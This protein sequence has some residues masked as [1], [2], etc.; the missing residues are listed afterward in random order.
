MCSC[1]CV[2]M[3]VCVCPGGGQKTTSSHPWACHPP[4]LKQ[5][6]S[7]GCNS[8]MGY[9]N[10]HNFKDTQCHNKLG[11]KSHAQRWPRRDGNRARRITKGYPFA[12][13][14]TSRLLDTSFLPCW[15][16]NP[17]SCTRRHITFTYIS[18]SHLEP[19]LN[20]VLGK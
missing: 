9:T 1:T 15:G 6:L 14:T 7:L 16:S 4:P 3:H 2:C 13:L 20:F 10:L 19:S 8:L 11:I 5:D 18:E 17:G 12:L